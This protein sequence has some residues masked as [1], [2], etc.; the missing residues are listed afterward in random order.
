MTTTNCAGVESPSTISVQVSPELTGPPSVTFRVVS[1]WSLEV[2][3]VSTPV[4]VDTEEAATVIDEPL[5]IATAPPPSSSLWRFEMTSE[6]CSP[7]P[8]VYDWPPACHVS[9]STAG[10]VKAKT[11]PA[12][13]AP[14]K[15]VCVVPFVRCSVAVNEP[16]SDV[17]VRTPP[18]DSQHGVA[19]P[20]REPRAASRR[21]RAT[22]R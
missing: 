10:P 5:T 7:L 21:R 12:S 18:V 13:A 4:A 19:A 14:A 2:E 8:T 3:S 20:G 15:S 6:R 17:I 9:P 22:C 11:T 16:L 1:A